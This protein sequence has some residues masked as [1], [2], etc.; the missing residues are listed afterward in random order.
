MSSSHEL[1]D[2]IEAV[3][4]TTADGDELLTVA[5]PPGEPIGVAHERI[6]RDHSSAEYGGSDRASR[7]VTDALEQA[8]RRLGE[9]DETP[10]NGLVL[11][12]GVVDGE[13]VEYVFDDLPSPVDESTYEQSNEFV[14][15][16]LETA[17]SASATFGLVVVEHGGAALGRLEDGS[18][19]AIET[20]DSDVPGK[21]R[22][23]GQSAERFDRD[24]E[25]RKEE[26]YDAVAAEAERAFLDD[27]GAV[28][29]SD[30]AGRD[31]DGGTPERP[32]HEDDARPGG[33]RPSEGDERSRTDGEADDPDFG[34]A[35]TIDGLLLGW[36]SVTIDEFRDGEFLDYRLQ[37]AIVDTVA[38][39]YASEQG[40]RQLAR[41]AEDSIEAAAQSDAREA[42]EE[43]F[44]SV[45]DDEVVYGR[46]RTGEALAYDAVDT[47]LLSAA[48][49]TEIARDLEERTAEQ[50]SDRV[51]VPADSERGQ[52]FEE[53]FGG[54]GAFLRFPID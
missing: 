53:A 10:D 20:F 44:E 29:P 3:A 51:V 36:T 49:P 43:F 40:L 19:D 30:G 11:Y 50:G 37:D 6:Q 46:D 17:A 52:R 5:V 1:Q 21:T 14:V 41:K 35:M 42:L 45:E 12:V 25:R 33:S 54:V 16:P 34:G 47:I 7:H 26:F 9:Y 48:L 4:D 38:V 27:P 23:G 32:G 13:V 22:A 15:D 8:R 31:A 18:V 2:R 28:V 24:R 39:E